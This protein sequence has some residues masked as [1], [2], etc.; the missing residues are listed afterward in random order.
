[1]SLDLP[2]F[3]IEKWMPIHFIFKNDFTP[4]VFVGVVGDCGASEDCSGCYQGQERGV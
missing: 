3:L 4:V 1:M 2:S